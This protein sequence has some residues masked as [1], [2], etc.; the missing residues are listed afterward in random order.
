M[1]LADAEGPEDGQSFFW[2]IDRRGVFFA[3]HDGYN[4]RSGFTVFQTSKH[5]YLGATYSSVF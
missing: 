5:N 3:E 1:L 4:G 2:K